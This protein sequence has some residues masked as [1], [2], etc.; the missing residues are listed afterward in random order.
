MNVGWLG[1]PATALESYV[2]SLG[3]SVHRAEDRIATDSPI[4][5]WAEFLIS[6]GYRHIIS[7][8]V[9][10]RFPRRAINLHI[11]CLPWNRGADPNLWSFLEN[12][13]TGVTIHYLDK[14]L[15]TG[16]ILAQQTVEHSPD[17]TLRSSY[18]RLKAAIEELFVSVWP[19]IRAGTQ[20]SFPQPPGGTSHR[21]R[22]RAQFE[23]LLARGWDTPVADLIGQ[24]LASKTEK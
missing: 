9:L 8:D 6:Y 21:S 15:D 14:G 13:P 5:E 3:D 22:D 4:I 19:H 20:A 17:D 24:A 18:D 1:P 7:G 12:T 2:V 16:D 23:H 11:S 10:N